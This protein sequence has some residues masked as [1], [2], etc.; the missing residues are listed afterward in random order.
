MICYFIVIMETYYYRLQYNL[1]QNVFPYY[2]Y[3]NKM[4]V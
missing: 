2:Y 3:K 4:I 1:L